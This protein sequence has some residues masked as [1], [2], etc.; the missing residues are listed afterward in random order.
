L[1]KIEKPT[2]TAAFPSAFTS[3]DYCTATNTNL[4]VAANSWVIDGIT[5]AKFDLWT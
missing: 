5:G 2:G 4:L 1:C 3:G